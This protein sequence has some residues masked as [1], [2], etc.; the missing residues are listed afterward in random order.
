ML[1]LP[2]MSLG[3]DATKLP[4]PYKPTPGHTDIVHHQQEWTSGTMGGG[5]VPDDLEWTTNPKQYQEEF[6][7][8]TVVEPKK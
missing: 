6:G 3:S 4:V 1:S 5:K 8:P 2:R 7:A